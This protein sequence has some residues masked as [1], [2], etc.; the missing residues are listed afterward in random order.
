MIRVEIL[1]QN[2]AA[3]KPFVML[4]FSLYKE[5]P[6]WVPPLIGEELRHLTEKKDEPRRFF[7]VYD[8][9][10]PV[11]RVMA[12]INERLNERFGRKYGYIALF[13]CA[14]KPDYA[15]AVLD[16]AC[17]YL[18]EEGME[19]VIGPEA[20]SEDVFS[21]GLLVQ[22]YDGTPMLFNPYNPPYY[23]EYFEKCG[24]AKHRDHL[25]YF[26]RMNEYDPAAMEEIV[27]RA[28]QRFGFRVEH[29]TLTPENEQRTVQNIARVIRE[30]FPA[31]W[32]MNT[33]TY[34]S[35][36]RS[37]KALKKYYRPELTVMAYADNRPIGLVAAF[38]D[39][40]LVLK[41]M[42]GRVLPIGWIEY[43]I[44][45]H[46]IR[47]ARCSMQFVVPE[48]QRRGVNL[49][50]FHEIFAGAKQLGIQWAEG[51]MVDETSPA[52]IANT[53]KLA[54]H[55][56]RVYREYEKTLTDDQPAAAEE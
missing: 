4:P 15:R 55:L 30:A 17:A 29:V 13:E 40:N 34:G 14:Q 52:S 7:L 23:S 43:L 9:E 39:Y 48:Y 25:A 50:M 32:E 18:K 44:W 45:R 51:S 38:P 54:S 26:M 8:E 28:K 12:G 36:L 27:H 42:K 6:N 49:A 41:K 33:P 56:Y 10:K 11:A 37:V 5:D 31:E 47:G 24:F 16:A 35:V 2:R 1:E 53:E 22:G 20:G 21:K 19:A 46:R 3:L